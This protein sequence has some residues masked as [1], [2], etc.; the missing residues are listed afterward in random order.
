VC[1]TCPVRAREPSVS[2]LAVGSLG[3]LPSPSLGAELAAHLPLGSL[4]ALVGLRA[5]P[6]VQTD[7]GHLSI[8]IVSGSVGLCVSKTLGTAHAVWCGHAEAGAI[9]AMARDLVPVDPGSYP[10]LALA[11]GPRVLWPVRSRFRLEAGVAGTVPLFRQRFR[12]AN[13][14]GAE[15]QAAPVG[16]VLF[17]G[18][19]AGT[20]E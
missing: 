20:G 16:G 2:A 15:F 13:Q 19:Q 8:G 18:I 5:L 9:T 11:T 6:P 1:P 10:W 12:V 7:D 3:L 14:E 17:L 4:D